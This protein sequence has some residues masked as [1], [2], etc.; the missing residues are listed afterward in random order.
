[1]T[2]SGRGKGLYLATTFFLYLFFLYL[3]ESSLAAQSLIKEYRLPAEVSSAAVLKVASDGDVW[4]TEKLGKHVVRF[5][6]ASGIFSVFEVPPDWGSVSPSA[7]T[8]SGD[9]VYF[10]LRKWVE[11]GVETSINYICLLD[12]RLEVFKRV[13]LVYK[14]KKIIPDELLVIESNIIW[15]ISTND[16]AL[17]RYD[18]DDDSL[19]FF[20]IP[21][22]SS[23]PKAL[24]LDPNGTL[25]FVLANANKVVSFTP[26]TNSFKEYLIPTKFFNP[27]ALFAS[28]D[29]VWISGMSSNSL[30]EL[31]PN[32]G[33]F[34][35]IPLPKPRRVPVSVLLDDEG[36]VWFLEYR[37]NAIGS[38]DPKTAV[39]QSFNIPT[40]NSLPL[41]L[42]LDKKRG[43]IWFAESST[44]A[45]RLGSRSLNALAE[46]N[47]LNTDA[48]SS[49]EGQDPW[50][51]VALF[52]FIF[53]AFVVYILRR[54]LR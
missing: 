20:P 31:N 3:P 50:V 27:V 15:F 42:A 35:E 2:R 28:V 18:L 21:T 34:F 25:W 54:R 32:S 48:A 11:G 19:R 46:N 49:G 12:P 53:S 6:P 10:T 1:M 7:I 14:N 30:A 26:L 36:I 29:R 33:V 37:G 23:L 40:F 4:F 22:E 24:S 9:M 38:F 52:A 8:L 45:R 41:S 5:E 47:S 39:F 51:K 43:L 16:N 44:E 13:E 17:Y